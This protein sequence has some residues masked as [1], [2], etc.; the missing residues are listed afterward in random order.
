MP[1][2]KRLLTVSIALAL[3]SLTAC[4]GGGGGGGATGTTAT[5]SSTSGTL[6]DDAVAGGTVFCDTNENQ[7]LDSGEMSAVTGDD[8]TYTFSSACTASIVSVA[9]TGTDISSNKAPR[10]HFRARAG[11]SIVSPFTTMLA[12]S[13][14]TLADFKAVMAKLGLGETDPGTFNPTAHANKHIALAVMKIFND[15]V[16]IATAAD[17]TVT[18]ADVFQAA[19]NA[20]VTHVNDHAVAGSSVL[21][22]DTALYGAI[23]AALNAAF[24]LVP[25]WTG[26]ATALANAKS[27]AREGLVTLARAIRNAANDSDADDAFRNE[28]NASLINDTDLHDNTAVGDA[29]GRCQDHDNYRHA[30]YV[31]SEGDALHLI[32][33]DQSEL[34]TTLGALSAT[35]GVSTPLTLRTLARVE[36]PLRDSGLAIPRSGVKAKLGIA[37]TEV[38][39]PRVLKLVV[40]KILLKPSTTT[41]GRLVAVVEGGAK[42]NFY[43]RNSS[44][45]EL[46]PAQPLTNLSRN[47]LSSGDVVG[48]DLSVITD[49]LVSNFASDASKTA[50]LNALLDSQGQFQIKVV[51]SEIDFRLADATRLSL[52]AVRLDTDGDRH[53]DKQ[54]R[55]ASFT[56]VIR[57]GS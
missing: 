18:G 34:D 54:V 52:G 19:V 33:T 40:D 46:Y 3:G 55:G 56:G 31:Y 22:D 28:G 45:V 48:I 4:G 17:A 41:T 9:G 35:N 36:M 12:G 39:G 24:A 49:R 2:K 29:R 1:L 14:M 30:R 16:A 53:A 13:G 51:I 5:P 21:D 15:I 50:L 44:G 42:L 25:A 27:I 6:V 23:D 10:G 47:V 11:S 57:F 7:T 43:A 37:V 26:D 38:G 32:G 20:F 8:G